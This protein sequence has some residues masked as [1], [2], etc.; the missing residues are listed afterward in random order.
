M[1]RFAVPS[2][3]AALVALA[4]RDSAT[5]PEGRLLVAESGGALRAA[6]SVASGDHV[7][8]PFAHTAGMV[9]LLSARVDQLRGRGGRGL[10]AGIGRA[11][12]GR[13]RRGLSP[14]PAGTIRVPN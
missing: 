11:L 12:G 10:R 2:D 5:L 4:D 7:A 9:R 6:M 8:D 13:S 3:A 1:I 14:Q